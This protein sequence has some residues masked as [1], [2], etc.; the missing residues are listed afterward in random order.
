MQR[1][2]RSDF[3]KPHHSNRDHSFM[4]VLLD[5]G[6]RWAESKILREARSA[7]TILPNA[8]LLNLK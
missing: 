4:L 3:L 2:L 7:L 5:T 1:L 8:Q 6:G